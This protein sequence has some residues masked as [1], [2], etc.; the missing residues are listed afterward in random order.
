MRN[1]KLLLVFVLFFPGYMD[2][3]EILTLEDAMNVALKN[4]PEIIKSELNMT[5]S[6]ENLN[7]R[8][9]A[10]KSLIKFNVTPF[11]Y[12]RTRSFNNQFSYWI[13]GEDIK[14]FGDL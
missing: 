12:S 9:A 1:F 10:T 2:G 11:S 5:I 4:S 3:Q 14:T 13:T 6:K 7:A 8:E